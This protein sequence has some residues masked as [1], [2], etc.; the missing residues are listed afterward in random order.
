MLKQQKEEAASRECTFHPVINH[1]SDRL[2][3]E[4]SEILKVTA[5][6]AAA[7]AKAA[8]DL[9]QVLVLPRRSSVLSLWLLLLLLVAYGRRG[10]CWH[11]PGSVLSLCVMPFP[12][13]FNEDAIQLVGV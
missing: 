5:V 12:T 4:R 2:M 3:A 13:A 11:S 6:A 9:Q 1:R 8:A 10:L 7:A